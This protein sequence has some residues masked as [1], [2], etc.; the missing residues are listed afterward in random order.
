MPVTKERFRQEYITKLELMYGDDAGHTSSLEKYNALVSLVRDYLAQQWKKTRAHYRRTGTKQVYYFSIE[1]LLGRLLGAN[2]FNLGLTEICREALAE[3]NIDLHELEKIE[4]DP[5]LGNG[6]LGRLAACYLDSMAAK[7][8][9]GHGMGIRYRYGLFE[10]RIIDGYQREFTDDWLMDGFYWDIRKPAEAVEVRFGGR[11]RIKSNGKTQYIHENYETVLAVPYDVPVAGY[12]NGLVNTLRLWSAEAKL[13]DIACHSDESKDCQKAVEFN[14]AVEEISNILYPDDT[15]YEGKVLRLK[16][17][18][19]LVSAG[20]QSILRNYKEQNGHLK[21]LPQKIAIHINDTHPVLTIPEL[22]RILI[23]EEKLE[24]DEAWKITVE[25]ISYT[26]HTILPEALEKWPVDLFKQ[27]LPRIY[28]IVEEINEGFCRS[29]WERYPGEWDRISA[30]AV[31]SYGQVHMAH[32]AIAG[33]HSVNGVA[34]LHTEILKH[35]VMRLFYEFSPEKFNNKTNGVTQRRWLAQCNPPVAALITDTI[36][37]EWIE[38]PQHL[39]K[40][41]QYVE[42]S[43]FQQYLSRAKLQNKV[44]LAKYIK[45][46]YDISLDINSIFD[47]HIKRI[48]AYKRQT[49]NILH[50]MD[51]Y[52]RLKDNPLLDITPRT[53]IFGGKAASNYH[54]AKATIKLINSLAQTVNNDKSIHDKIKIIFMEN[55]NVSLAELIIPASDVSEQIPTAS[56]E[57]SGTGNMKFMMNGA[58]TIGTLDGANIEIK[59]AV[60]EENI[61]VFGLTADEVLQYYRYGGYNPWDVYNSD[62]RVRTV[63]EQLING[64]LPAGKEVFRDHYDSLLHQGDH[65]FV[66]KDFASYVQAQNILEERFRNKA[67]WLKMCACNIAH[68]GAFS[69]DRTF[70]EYAAEIWGVRPQ[71]LGN[72]N[73]NRSTGPVN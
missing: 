62:Q 19:F 5:G 8:L 55:Y 22:M 29:L 40:L 46:K 13:S 2:L 33:S 37:A 73:G 51:L 35:K 70:S 21:E 14:H 58:V 45:G 25:T 63:V 72:G 64:F 67:R 28:M 34:A 11:V 3:L 50:I 6:G 43:G 9:P 23:D 69:S 49:L 54:I 1:F 38:S 47:A 18:Y 31:I 17:Q 65:F 41:K 48:H 4:E 56:Y 53:F 39:I 71:R 42:D 26:N 68:S 61:I 12:R 30:M 52:N 57:A 44:M 66:L 20:L 7:N 36:G 27:V 32:L 16:Q 15:T 24:W 59:N 60:G 10:Q